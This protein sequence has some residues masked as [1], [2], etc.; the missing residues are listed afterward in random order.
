MQSP[1]LYT[2]NTHYKNTFQHCKAL[3][4]CNAT[5]S[6]TTWVRVTYLS[7]KLVSVKLPKFQTEA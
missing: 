6:N 4:S 5:N 1:L 3:K 2:E 7:V